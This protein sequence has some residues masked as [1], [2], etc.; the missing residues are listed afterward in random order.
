[1]FVVAEFFTLASIADPVAFAVKNN[2][3]RAGVNFSGKPMAKVPSHEQ[4]VAQSLS[5]IKTPMGSTNWDNIAFVPSI[6]LRLIASSGAGHG[7][8]ILA[9][10][11]VRRRRAALPWRSQPMH[12]RL[13]ATLL[14]TQ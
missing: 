7:L 12:H 8:S 2:E 11:I 13:L 1:M 3:A 9:A 4:L 14:T 5:A 6:G 10:D